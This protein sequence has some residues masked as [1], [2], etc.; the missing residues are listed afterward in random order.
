MFQKNACFWLLIKIFWD[1]ENC[2]LVNDIAPSQ[3]Y[4]LL[5]KVF[6]ERLGI[7]A[8]DF[9]LNAG[10]SDLTLEA[11]PC[12]V[13]QDI[14]AVESMYTNIQKCLGTKYKN[15]VTGEVVDLKASQ[16]SVDA[17]LLQMM[18]RYMLGTQKDDVLVLI[19]GDKDYISHLTAAA[20]TYQLQLLVLAPAWNST[21]QG[22]RDMVQLGTIRWF[23][24]FKDFI[25]HHAAIVDKPAS[26][27]A[28]PGRAEWNLQ[29][30]VRSA[31]NLDAEQLLLPQDGNHALDTVTIDFFIKGMVT[32]FD[33]SFAENILTKASFQLCRRFLINGSL[34]DPDTLKLLEA[35][36][37]PS[38]LS[39]VFHEAN[40]MAPRFL[41]EV[42]SSEGGLRM[43]FQRKL[44][45]ELGKGAETASDSNKDPMPGGSVKS[46][47]ET[48][49][50]KF[51]ALV[52]HNHSFGLC[53]PFLHHGTLI[54]E[55]TKKMLLLCASPGPLNAAFQKALALSPKALHQALLSPGGLK[56]WFKTELTDIPPSTQAPPAAAAEG[57]DRS[58]D[59]NGRG[60]TGILISRSK[61]CADV[62]SLVYSFDRTFTLQGSLP[63]L[64]EIH[65]EWIFTRQ[66]DKA[67][68]V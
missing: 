5:R 48:F 1:M 12:N 37:V 44:E 31:Q 27:L 66:G 36:Q 25:K 45:E 47:V 57:L 4:R 23:T 17:K 43:W 60:P 30:A 14:T 2:P 6:K 50:H 59:S 35:C 42:L 7:Q 9:M 63:G 46:M 18:N 22:Y 20:E 64:C 55:S 32:R 41:L 67:S 61:N 13:R 65:K 51:A 16:H 10:I 3:H 24:N 54:D 8:R 58:L 62:K 21:A 49:E 29:A 38:V 28:M 52:L 56:S 39:K 68:F 53:R 26:Q 33:R 15:K 11:L 19:C 34:L 40:Q